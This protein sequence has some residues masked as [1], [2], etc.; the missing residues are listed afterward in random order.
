MACFVV[1]QMQ[2]ARLGVPHSVSAD[3]TLIQALED[4]GNPSSLVTLCRI[5]RLTA[6]FTTTI[7]ANGQ[8]LSGLLEPTTRIDMVRFFGAELEKLQKEHFPDMSQIVQI[9][10]LTSKLHLWSFVLHHDIPRS[11]DIIEF[12]YQAEHDAA[13]LIFLASEK[14]LS[15]CPFHVARSVLYAALTLLRILVSPYARQPTV[16]YDQIM[17]A[18]KTLSSAVKVSDDHAQ[19]WSRHLQQLVALRDRKRTPPVRARMSASLVYD[20]I[21]VM[22]EH[23]NVPEN[24]ESQQFESPEAL[25]IPSWMNVES[26]ARLLDLDGLNW[27]DIGALL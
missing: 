5:S 12:F 6:Q 16:I 9:S 1:N 24:Q 22:K 7:G 23:I 17:L 25:N 4:P 8:N 10:Y 11:S 21:R 15:R 26:G 20:A 27:D 14:N 3:Y 18:S 19:R 13:S 2:T